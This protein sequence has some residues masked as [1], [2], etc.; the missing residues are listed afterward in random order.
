MITALEKLA[1]L[2]DER[3]AI[4]SE[5]IAELKKKIAD[6]KASLRADE[7]ELAR[8]SGET[9]VR[10]RGV[11]GDMA[12]DDI[13]EGALKLLATEE[14]GLNATNIAESLNVSSQQVGKVL[15]KEAA[16]KDGKIKRE[17]QAKG[18][19]YLLRQS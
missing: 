4:I 11:V 6:T 1:K 14:G 9:V 16:N 18:T 8:L 19:K 2:D 5:A 12:D 13:L 10:T 7:A 3:K 15:K 17:G